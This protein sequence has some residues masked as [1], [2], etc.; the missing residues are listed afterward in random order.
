MTGE[1]FTPSVF[2]IEQVRSQEHLC[3]CSKVLRYEPPCALCGVLHLYSM[4]ITGRVGS[5]AP[6]L[7]ESDKSNSKQNTF[8]ACEPYLSCSLTTGKAKGRKHLQW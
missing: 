3:L 5:V 8:S 4:L 1:K 2:S 6:A 7:G